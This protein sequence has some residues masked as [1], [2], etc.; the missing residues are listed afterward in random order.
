M[1]PLRLAVVGCGA[2]V[3]HCH[4]P[5]LLSGPFTVA[6]LVDRDPARRE[7]MSTHVP[8]AA[9]LSDVSALDLSTVDAALV[10]TG[11]ASHAAIASRL[12]SAGLPVLLE[13]PVAATPAECD[14][15]RAAAGDTLVVPA[16]VRRHYPA[17]AWV[18]A[19]LASGRLGRVRRVRWREG[20]PYAW[21][22]VSAF[23]FAPGPGGGVR[24][25]LGP[26][27]LDLL[28]L[29]LGGTGDLVSCVDNA[30]GG[31]DSETVLS[32]RY[33]DVF[34]DVTLSRL[35]TL[36]GR[37]S[38][39]GAEATLTVDTARAADY[40]LHA[41]DGALL[42]SGAVPAD[43]PELLTRA[44]LFRH[45]LTRFAAAV[46]A[47]PGA[48]RAEPAVVRAEPGAVR[49]EPAVV[50]AGSAAVRAGSGGGPATLE[51]AAAV[52]RLLAR[53]R[54]R[55]THDLPRP[56]QPATVR[57]D[58]A[59]DGLRIAVTGANGFIGAQVTEHLLDAGA[60]EVSAVVRTHA[61]RARLAHRPP[62]RL[63]LTTADLRDE[64]A[65]R[66][67]FDGCDVVVHAAYGSRGEPADRYAV[68]VDGAAAVLAAAA[69]TGVRRLIN[70]SSVAVYPP[71]DRQILDETAPLLVPDPGDYSYAAQKAAADRLLA[72]FDGEVVS[73]QPSA[74]YG[75]AGPKWTM[76]P[77]RRLREDNACLPGGGGGVCDVVHVHDVARAIAFLAT[78]DVPSHARFLLTGPEPATWGDYYD[79]YRD[80]LRLPRPH[81]PD[82]PRWP[83]R[84]REFYA[85]RTRVDAGRLAAAG[86][87]PRLGLD[88]G[89]ATVAAWARWAGLA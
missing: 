70:L 72:D 64:P 67:A 32:L 14:A 30:R 29:W 59:L 12:A 84:E 49:A 45:Q 7:L 73:L 56:W 71:G 1:S 58:R 3:E 23:T 39:E 9:L 25:D 19:M 27:I 54:E 80:L 8:S 62:D 74:V 26:H 4:L 42:E 16:L 11:P 53:C 77:L 78:A 20:G 43:D 47:E 40:T 89:L 60:R 10:A 17:T 46:R 34:A 65:L 79:R 5:A 76:A 83:D 86:F 69:K 2:V 75:P 28:G 82:S 36:G 68:T 87:H 13:K 55:A 63:R 31:A 18:A 50:R 38:I 15:L 44:G 21:P 88:E 24:A 66:D 35:R 52:V 37:V 51:E 81:L 6:A 48:V 61:G 57:P 22:L 85:R 41:A 33:G